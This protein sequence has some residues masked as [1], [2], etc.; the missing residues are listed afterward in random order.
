MLR[1]ACRSVGLQFA[2]PSTN[3]FPV[4]PKKCALVYTINGPAIGEKTSE[5]RKAENSAAETCWPSFP[6]F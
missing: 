4:A 5:A 1:V 6:V 3:Q 2:L